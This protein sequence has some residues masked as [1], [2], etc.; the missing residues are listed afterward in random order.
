M[1][2]L[3]LSTRALTRF[4]CAAERCED[5][6]C[7]GWRVSLRQEDAERLVQISSHHVTIDPDE[8]AANDA[9][10]TASTWLDEHVDLNATGTTHGA[11]R[12]RADGDCSFLQADRLCELQREH[13]EASLPAVCSLYP[14]VS[15]WY[16]DRIES[17]AVISC[18]EYA[19]ELLLTDDGAEIQPT[20]PTALPREL[21]LTDRL[22][23]TP[24][25]RH[26]EDVRSVIVRLLVPPTHSVRHRL[27]FWA[28]F[29]HRTRTFFHRDVP[30]DGIAERLAKE[31]FPFTQAPVR[32]EIATKLDHQAVPAHVGVRFIKQ[33]LELLHRQRG[34]SRLRDVLAAAERTYSGHAVAPADSFSVLADTWPLYVARREAIIAVAGDRIDRAMLNRAK[35]YAFS[36]PY[37]EH[38]TLSAHVQRLLVE[39]ALVR[40]LVFSQPRLDPLVIAANHD[41]C[42]PRFA[43]LVD[44]SIVEAFSA[45]ARTIEHDPQIRDGLGELIASVGLT[46]LA[47]SVFLLAV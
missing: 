45:T 12:R 20:D 31:M 42:D 35:D 24:Y 6:C 46:G 22:A 40:F 4:R 7:H 43:A 32:A 16:E 19:R 2:T 39:L 28:L 26:F 37:T 34:S 3:G 8:S 25:G 23:A 9:G 38:A 17:S 14:R 44:E 27:F 47:G 33:L 15:R 41:G 21:A 29:A 1:P 10:P 11:L 5:S 30:P 18:P 36:S 13:G